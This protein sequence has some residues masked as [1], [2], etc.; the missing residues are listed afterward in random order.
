MRV[1][2]LSL[3]LPFRFRTECLSCLLH[4]TRVQDILSRSTKPATGLWHVH[5]GRSTAQRRIALNW[6]DANSRRTMM[7]LPCC[8]I[9]YARQLGDTFTSAIVVVIHMTIP[10]SCILTREWFRIPT[11]PRTRLHTAFT[12]AAWVSSQRERS[13]ESYL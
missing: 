10:K 2:W 7:V 9:W 5:D 6:T 11:R 1:L 4:L 3:H 12:G 8:A 13:S